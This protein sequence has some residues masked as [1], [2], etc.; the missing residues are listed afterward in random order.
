M[1]RRRPLPD[2]DSMGRSNIIP[3]SPL[4]GFRKR[5]RRRLK[6][7]LQYEP[8]IRAWCQRNRWI[9]AIKNRGHHWIFSRGDTV[10]EWWPSSA[11]LIVDKRWK[12]GIHCHDYKQVLKLLGRYGA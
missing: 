1:V 11:K 3:F 10:I 9:L 8:E 12:E 2:S 4:E 7:N 5:H 6:A